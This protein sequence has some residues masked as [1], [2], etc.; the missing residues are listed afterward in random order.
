MNEVDRLAA[1]V[2][3]VAPTGR[4]LLLRVEARFRDPFWV[5]PGGGL[6][7]GEAM[8]AAALR[9]LAEE[10]GR[11][12]LS[13][14]PHLW[15]ETVT[16]AWGERLVRQEQSTFL[17][18]APEEFEPVVAHADGEPITGGAW[19]GPAELAAM[20]ETVYPPTLAE[21][22]ARILVDGPPA[23]PLRLSSRVAPS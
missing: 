15:S 20:A 1:R 7:E 10:A 19:F 8:E 22:L 2:L 21:L 9:E 6:D 14:G 13:L 5:T 11:T 16:F 12:D 18:V 17:V 4:A 23:V 3:V